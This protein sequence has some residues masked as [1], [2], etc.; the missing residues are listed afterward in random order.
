MTREKKKKL[1]K[2]QEWVPEQ[3]Q[4]PPQIDGESC[5]YRMLH[6]TNGV[7][8]QQELQTIDEAEAALEG[9]VIE[10]IR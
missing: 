6:S 5:G 8:K 9:Y 7:C 3:M 4:V 1:K 2:Q 10:S